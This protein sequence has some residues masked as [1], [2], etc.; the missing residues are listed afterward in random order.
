MQHKESSYHT[1]ES[2]SRFARAVVSNIAFNYSE[3]IKKGHAQDNLWE[4]LA[5]PIEAGWELYRNKVED[6]LVKHHRYYE[7]ALVDILMDPNVP[8][9]GEA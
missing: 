1:P 7:H 5:Q 2:A 3:L 6:Q 8:M 4:V 9:L